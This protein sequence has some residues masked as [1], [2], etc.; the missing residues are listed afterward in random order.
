[1]EPNTNPTQP[2]NNLPPQ[3]MMAPTPSPVTGYVPQVPVGMPSPQVA[4]QQ[5]YQQMPT[6]PVMAPQ[7]P[8]PQMPSAQ[9]MMT[10]PTVPQNQPSSS[11]K[12]VL[13]IAA[14]IV[15]VIVVAA[16]T[17]LVFGKKS[18]TK[19][20]TNSASTSSLITPPAAD[21]TKPA[22][23]PQ[24]TEVTLN[25]T[26]SITELGYSVQLIKIERNVPN[27]DNKDTTQETI[28]IQL[29]G[30]NDTGKFYGGPDWPDFRII[31][32]GGEE[33]HTEP[34]YTTKQLATANGDTAYDGSNIKKGQPATGLIAFVIPANA[35]KLTFRYKLA[36]TKV[37]GGSGGTIA[38]KDYD[39]AL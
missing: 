32:D 16:V 24:K 6:M 20:S 38:A 4:P 22:A 12:K 34:S 14:I 30:S 19:S 21:T 36:S 29:K 1:M 25:K 35:K 28:L 9:P 3:P 26:I 10:Y 13:I 18:T 11:K 23:A 37:I 17:F 39:L 33:I 31:A 27:S 2:T 15:V 5:Q 8:S 7:Q